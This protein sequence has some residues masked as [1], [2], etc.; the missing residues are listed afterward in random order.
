MRTLP[1]LGMQF[2]VNNSRG[3]N[4]LGLKYHSAQEAIIDQAEFQ[5]KIGIVKKP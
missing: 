4:E 3:V 5:I 1:F 2:A